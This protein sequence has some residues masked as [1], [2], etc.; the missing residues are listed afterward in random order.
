MQR[1]SLSLE[2]CF[3][4]QLLKLAHLLDHVSDGLDSIKR[5]SGPSSS[6]VVD[7]ILSLISSVKF[8]V[9]LGACQV[10]SVWHIKVIKTGVHIAI[11]SQ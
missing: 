1:S 10:T 6:G 11:A 3:S 2:N 4:F 9:K 7:I 8:I 5:W